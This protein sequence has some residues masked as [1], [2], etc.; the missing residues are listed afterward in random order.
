M[1]R[2]IGCRSKQLLSMCEDGTKKG[3]CNPLMAQ[4]L[5]TPTIHDSGENHFAFK[6]RFVGNARRIPL[7][8]EK[9]SHAVGMFFDDWKGPSIFWVIKNPTCPSLKTLP[10]SGRRKRPI[11]IFPC[12]LGLS[13]SLQN[14]WSSNVE[15]KN[16]R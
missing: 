12:I 2:K 7:I 11:G 15:A 6:T 8:N 14:V 16:F 5:K 13:K 9:L 3:Q 4:F 1:P 10:P